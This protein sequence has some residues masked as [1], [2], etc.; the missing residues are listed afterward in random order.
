MQRQSMN[1]VSSLQ[2]RN[3]FLVG[4]VFQK[5]K[6]LQKRSK[7]S[8]L[9]LFR[10]A[11][12]LRLKI[13]GCNSVSKETSPNLFF[14]LNSKSSIWEGIFRWV[15]DADQNLHQSELK[16]FF[17]FYQPSLFSRSWSAVSCVCGGYRKKLLKKGQRFPSCF[18]MVVLYRFS[19]VWYIYSANQNWVFK[20][21]K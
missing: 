19:L 1:P 15:K 18:L 7:K 4:V 8:I 14:G 21:S 9:W 5:G 17:V 16:H 10:W 12:F 6:K 20:F 13:F 3:S 11:N 2:P